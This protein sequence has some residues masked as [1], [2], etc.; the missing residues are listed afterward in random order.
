MLKVLQNPDYYDSEGFLKTRAFRIGITRSAKDHGFVLLLIVLSILAIGATVL[1]AGL[2]AGVARTEQRIARAAVSESVL[3]DA[4][5]ILIAYIVSPPSTTSRPSATIRPGT[6]PTPDSLGNG[7][8]DGIEDDNCLGNTTNGLPAVGSTSTIRRCLGK[9]PWKTVPIDAASVDSHDPIGRVPWLAVSSNLIFNDSCLKVLNSDIANLASPVT[10][11][12]PGVALPY[13]QPTALPHPWL[14]VYDQNGMVLSDKV[15]AVLILPGAP[16]TTESRTQTRST[17]S[18][19]NPSDYLDSVNLPLGCTSGCTL[20]D[21]AGLNNEFIMIPSGTNYPGDAQDTAK[22]GQPLRFNDVLVYLTIDEV[23]HY[24]EKRVA[25][26]IATALKTFTTDTTTGFTK[27][28]WLQ[29]LSA[30]F[31]DSTS[32]YSQQNTIFGAFPFMTNDIDAKYRTDFSWAL[33]GATESTFWESTTGTG[34]TATSCY[35]I[36]TSPSN[37]WVRNPLVATLNSSTSHGGPFA[38][39]GAIAA[40]SGTCKWL[41]GT[42]VECEYDAGTLSQS[43]QMYSNSTCTATSSSVTLSVARKISLINDSAGC[44]AVPVLSYAAASGTNV[45]RWSWACNSSVQPAIL[46]VKDTISGV[47]YSGLPRVAR[48]SSLDD[49]VLPPQTFALN[50]MRYHPIMPI[51]F[52]HNR[53]YPTAFA[54]WAPGA[55]KLP[56]TPSPNPCNLETSLKVGGASVTTGVIVL[57]GPALTGQSRPAAAISSYLEGANTSAGT[58][59]AL[60]NSEAPRSLT[61]NDNILVLMP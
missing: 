22:R 8:Y 32:L 44:N 9:F 43:F 46:E 4:R 25:G 30:S 53:W 24:A 50:G 17:S 35:R 33:T 12:C 49:G 36:R 42:K 57:A 48:L 56:I 3:N 27:Y 20:Y 31:A 6:L 58:T 60:V 18:P 38:S 23:M 51:W 52:F 19:G 10:P 37:R 5:Q 40:T 34:T 21:N 45:H 41:G 15:A 7:N 39:S 61:L 13:P 14:K 28:P 55:A 47:G 1:F 2:G 16:I 54:S 11:S 59:C 29:P 26:Q